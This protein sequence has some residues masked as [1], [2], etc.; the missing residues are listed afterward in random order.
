MLN[1][2][3]LV[4]GADFFALDAPIN[5]YYD[6]NPVNVAEAM[7]EHAA[8][9]NAFHDAGIEIIKV[10]PPSTSQ[11]GVYTANWGLVRDGKVVLSRLPD[12]RVSE[13]DYAAKIFTE[14]GLEVIR[15]PEDWHF[16]GQGDALPCGRFL[17]AGSGYR[18]DPRASKFAADALG[19]ELIQLHAVP[20]L[21]DAGNPCLNPSSGWAD[22]FFYDID[23]AIS[24]LRDDLIAYCPDAFDDVSRARIAALPVDKITVSYEEAVKGLACN[25]VSTGETVIMSAHAPNLRSEIEKRGLNVTP[26]HAPELA[27]G[28]GYIRCVSLTLGE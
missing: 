16:S 23:L 20:K 5:P 12:A 8:I 27:R 11:D 17:L 22:S 2:K 7:R 21:D 28:G 4:S 3:I 6:N 26:I 25:L 13:E 1:T 15:V 24:V 9:L 18:S 14:L 10:V 19:F